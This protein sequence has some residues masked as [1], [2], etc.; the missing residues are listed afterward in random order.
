[1]QTDAHG[2]DATLSFRCSVATVHLARAAAA[3][4]GVLV[5]DWLRNVTEMALRREL[6]GHHSNERASGPER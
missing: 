5:S 1:M 4:N 2:K 6:T 3:R